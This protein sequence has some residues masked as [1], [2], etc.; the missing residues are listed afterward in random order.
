MVFVYVIEYPILSHAKLPYRPRLL[1]GWFQ[2]LEHLLAT[3]RPGWLAT[4][5][6]ID[7][8]EDPP[9]VPCAD[10]PEL[11][12]CALL[13][14]NRVGQAMSKVLATLPCPVKPTGR[15]V[16]PAGVRSSEPHIFNHGVWREEVEEV[17][18]AP[19]EDRPGRDG[20]R[21]A[22]GQTE[23]GRHLRVVYVPD[24]DPGSV[25]VITAYELTGK[26]LLAYRRRRRRRR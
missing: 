5:M 4:E 24:R 9:R 11:S 7:F 2:A 16:P 19:G 8:I 10:L 26:P 12:F 18:R 17:L 14:A 21:I 20:A 6:Q 23:S 1:P 25:F 22:I 13:V 15:Y 3:A